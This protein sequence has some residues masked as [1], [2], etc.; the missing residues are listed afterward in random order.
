MKRR[1]ASYFALALLAATAL[2]VVVVLPNAQDVQASTAMLALPICEFIELKGRM[3][4]DMSELTT[5]G[6]VRKLQDGSYECVSLGK[7]INRINDIHVEWNVNTNSCI[8]SQDELIFRPT[9]EKY[10]IVRPA[11]FSLPGEEKAAMN[12]S[13]MIYRKLVNSG[14]SPDA[15]TASD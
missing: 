14:T 12:S 9:G 8:L 7:T 6:M 5:L 2:W 15:K 1:I 4:S 3:P 11:H 10:F 13:V